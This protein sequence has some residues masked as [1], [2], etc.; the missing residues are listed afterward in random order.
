MGLRQPSTYF[1]VVFVVVFGEEVV[2]KN[3]HDGVLHC[4][5]KLHYTIVQG[6]VLLS[7]W[8]QNSLSRG[9]GREEKKKVGEGERPARHTLR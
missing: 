3:M 5:L 1:V 7:L 6:W 4:Y 9:T 8:L 2:D